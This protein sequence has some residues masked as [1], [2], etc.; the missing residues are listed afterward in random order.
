MK[1]LNKA[2][3]LKRSAA[4]IV[5]QQITSFTLA[6]QKP[7]SVELSSTETQCIIKS[8]LPPRILFFSKTYHKFEVPHS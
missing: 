4:L 7:E 6:S 2:A 1:K 3:L 8:V 5:N